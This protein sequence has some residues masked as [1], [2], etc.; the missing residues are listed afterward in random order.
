MHVLMVPITK[1]TEVR[2]KKSGSNYPARVLPG[3][4]ERYSS[5]TFLGGRDGLKMLQTDLAKAVG[6]KYGLER[7]VE[8]STAR[9]TNQ[10]EWASKLKKEELAL[11]TGKAALKADKALLAKD[12][13]ELDTAVKFWEEKAGPAFDYG[14]KMG[15]IFHG[16]PN[17]LYKEGWAVLA[18]WGD[19][20][21]AE[22][23]LKKAPR[24][25]RKAI[26]KSKGQ[27]R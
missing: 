26:D 4:S 15:E 21:R 17:E 12:R 6:K 23:A 25:T 13:A 5:S 18:K 20:K 9:H 1:N 19:E 10:Q 11:A 2:P 27:S 24:A 3:E 14:M 8:G 22:L 7:G 16:I